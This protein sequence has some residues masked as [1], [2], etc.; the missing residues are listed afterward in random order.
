MA[1]LN[2]GAMNRREVLQLGAACGIGV[3]LGDVFLPNQSITAAS[4]SEAAVHEKPPIQTRMFWT[5]DHSTEWALNRLGAHTHGSCN[6][7]GRTTQSFIDDY[8]ALFRW[9]GR[10]NVDAVVVWGLLRDG[11][12]GL[13]SAKRLC[14]VAAKENVRLLCGV[15]LNAYGGVY[16]EGDSPYNLERHLQAHPELYAVDAEGNSTNFSIDAIGTRVRLANTSTPGP[17]GFYHACPSRMENQEFAVESLKW[18]FRNL[19]LGGVQIETGDTGVC[20]CPLCRD[21]RKH[22]ADTFSWEDMALMYPLAAEAVRSVAPDAWIVCETY[23]HPEPYTGPK[24]APGFGDGKA[25]WADESLTK[26][27]RGAFVQW[28][29]DRYLRQADPDRVWTDKGQVSC[30]G[31]RHV[32]RA[33]VGTDWGWGAFR[34]EVALEW[35]S[36][37]V[38]QSV[39]SGFEGISLFGEVSPF[40]TGAELNYLAL[41]DLGSAN[42]PT[43]DQ[44]VFEERIAGP[45]LGGHSHAIDFVRFA[46]LLDARFPNR[47]TEI[48]A[49]ISSI[50]SR[51]PLLSP[52]V[53]RRWCWL[54]NQLASFVY[55]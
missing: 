54:A 52:E 37:L 39:S 46:G 21:R 40:H 38:Q 18:L 28:V 29:A 24:V 50:Y 27:P 51:L 32:M 33:H 26:F 4:A 7:Y 23:S 30:D 8:T 43:S 31:L 1:A 10:N 14:D 3:S 20:Q 12:G 34:G 49:A 15:G 42:N 48:P 9:C 47:R 19:E 6:E 2:L 16:Y 35:I 44:A 25:A 41:S 53:G 11:H 55:G 36:K 13:E 22:P 17:R 5:W 45:L